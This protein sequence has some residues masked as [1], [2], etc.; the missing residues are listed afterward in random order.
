MKT[1]RDLV[2]EAKQVVPEISVEE[3]HAQLAGAKPPTV[4]DVRDPDENREGAIEGAIPISR[5]FLEFKIQDA[6]P[7][8]ETPVTAWQHTGGKHRLVTPGGVVTAG[9]V[10]FATNGYTPE[11]LDPMLAGR[12][13]PALSSI[14]VTRPLPVVMETL[15]VAAGLSAMRRS[16]FLVASLVGTTPVAFAYAWAGQLA[17]DSGTVVPA[18]VILLA[19]VAAGWLIARPVTARRPD[20]TT[21]PPAASS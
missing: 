18:V 12:L 13:L 2:N 16:T 8:P 15:S 10:L 1:Y 5:G 20:T 11:G 6:F 4:L 14:I 7:D 3:L 17:I 19:V 21:P 9:R